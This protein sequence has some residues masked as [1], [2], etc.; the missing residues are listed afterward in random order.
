MAAVGVAGQRPH[1]PPGEQGEVA[2]ILGLEQAAQPGHRV[3]PWEDPV[4]L[5]RLQQLERLADAVAQPRR[6]ALARFGLGQLQGVVLEPVPRV[7]AQLAGVVVLAEG[8]LAAPWPLLG[9]D[10]VHWLSPLQGA[11]APSAG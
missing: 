10:L 9:L 4:A 3:A 1:D 11:V 2:I 6:V 5:D 7:G 8:Q